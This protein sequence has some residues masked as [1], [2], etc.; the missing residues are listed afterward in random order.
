MTDGSVPK[1]EYRVRYCASSNISFHNEFDPWE[2]W[3][4]DEDSA[5]AIEASLNDMHGQRWNTP[6]GFEIALERSG[7]EWWVEVREAE[8]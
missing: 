3:D 1:F 5:G 6:D 8:A 7:F 4:G 2:P